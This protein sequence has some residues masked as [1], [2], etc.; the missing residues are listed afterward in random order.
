[1][2]RPTYKPIFISAAG[3]RSLVER[4][5]EDICNLNHIGTEMYGNILF[6]VNEMLDILFHLRKEMDSSAA[7]VSAEATGNCL[8][9]Q[10]RMAE[11]NSEKNPWYD[12]IE[13]EIRKA[14]LEKE[15][16]I[17][18]KLADKLILGKDNLYILAE[19]DNTG[20]RY[21]RV[22]ERISSLK[23]YWEKDPAMK[24]V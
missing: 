21:E 7:E 12:E 15:L 9:F 1:M 16:Y 23:R 14:K 2:I 13:E 22:M 4:Y 18:R 17:I 3:N 5:V 20:M 19:F 10:V 6:S 24:G 8:R 11:E